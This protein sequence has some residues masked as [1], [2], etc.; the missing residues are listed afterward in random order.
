MLPVKRLGLGIALLV[1]AASLV[2]L[3]RWGGRR[4]IATPQP[5]SEAS[6]SRELVPVPPRA[7]DGDAVPETRGARAAAETMT[8]A[9]PVSEPEPRPGAIAWTVRARLVDERGAPLAGG[10]LG[11]L[12]EG[13]EFFAESKADGEV[14]L[15]LGNGRSP[16]GPRWVFEA[17]APGRIRRSVEV[18]RELAAG[19]PSYFLGELVLHPGGSLAG[20]VVDERGSIVPLARVIARPP[21]TEASPTERVFLPW[22]WFG[23]GIRISGSC[24]PDGSYRLDGVPCGQVEVLA[25]APALL[26]AR[27]GVLEVRAGLEKL[28]PDLVLGTPLDADRIAG[29]VTHPDGRPCPRLDVWLATKEGGELWPG[30]KSDADGRFALL[31]A[32][33]AVYTLQAREPSTLQTAKLPGVRAGDLGV[34]LVFGAATATIELAVRDE[35]GPVSGFRVVIENEERRAVGGAR[36]TEPGLL[37]FERPATVFH[38]SVISPLHLTQRLGPFD[39]ARTER[40]EVVLVRAG[41]V[42]GTVLSGQSG[43]PVP[44]A[45]VH[46]HP[47]IP[48]ASFGLLPED[49]VT[50]LDP[51]ISAETVTDGSGRFFLPLQKS[52]RYRLHASSSGKALGASAWVEHTGALAEGFDILLPVPGA[53]E[54]RVLVAS[55]VDARG[56]WIGASDGEGHVELAQTGENGAF[57]FAE[58]A[59]GRWQVHRIQG[60]EAQYLV[61]N[62]TYWAAEDESGPPAFDVEVPAGRT[63]IFDIDARGEVPCSLEGRL[64]FDG[65]GAQG[66]GAYLDVADKSTLLDADG[67]FTLRAPKPGL[68]PLYLS[69]SDAQFEH[70]LELAAGPNTWELDLPVG[71]VQLENLPP[72]PPDPRMG[73]QENWP[74][75]ELSW[76]RGEL[77]WSANLQESPSASARLANVPA[78]ELVLRWRSGGAGPQDQRNWPELARIELAAGK[79]ATLRLP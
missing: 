57:G 41:G 3:A 47:A 14:T 35:R 8:S 45:A 75:Y 6:G 73:R 79:L 74:E 31:A 32:R 42:S 25:S 43:A 55:G 12:L 19:N 21:A 49:F 5:A 58:L 69:G 77:R 68:Y 44:G 51:R 17:T 4:P 1:I 37:R 9:A 70:R 18:D 34:E 61:R 60:A 71:E 78:G 28:V 7:V 72:V 22:A 24:G 66:F 76:S 63:V 33:D 2:F 20:R 29:R 38:L 46:A 10:R 64:A 54:G 62:R 56:T 13:K 23:D 50:F 67:R 40:L 30:T 65:E 39:P 52:G 36:S 27:S 48:E 11:T 15:A 53:I 26:V 59:P 16:S